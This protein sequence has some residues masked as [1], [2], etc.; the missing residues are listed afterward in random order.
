MKRFITFIILLFLIPITTPCFAQQKD[1]PVLK[2]PYLGRK[3]PGIT[4]EIF[5]PG[6][7]TTNLHDDGSPIFSPDGNE[8]WFRIIT[9]VAPDY[10]LCLFYM[11][12]KGGIW[13]KPVLSSFTKKYGI[14]SGVLSNDGSRFYFIL[15]KP[16]NDRLK[17]EISRIWYV[18][19]NNTG[20]SDPA[21]VGK[22]VDTPGKEMSLSVSPD[23]TLYFQVKDNSGDPND[24]YYS[25][26]EN[27]KYKKPEVLGPPVKTGGW[28]QAPSLAP[29]G[30]YIVF[31]GRLRR[32]KDDRGITLYVSF[33]NSN[34][35]WSEPEI[36]TL[37]YPGYHPGGRFSRI[38]PDGKYLFFTKMAKNTNPEKPKPFS[39]KWDAEI[40][41]GVPKY[42]Y[43]DADVFWVSTSIIEK[44][45]QGIIK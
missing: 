10:V 35:T 18:D 16:V 32:G 3:P 13:T 8:V 40:L 27:G 22:T 29:D 6:I 17:P 4:P 42:K 19:R 34:N 2:G 21:A 15:N 23:N 37:D 28:E 7:V 26:F 38:S 5:A 25:R 31:T 1:F 44:L 41:K 20:W 33:L 39:R 43:N 12:Q 11:K 30:S 45:K 36:L 14:S 9:G 24:I